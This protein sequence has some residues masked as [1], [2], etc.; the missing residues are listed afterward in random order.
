MCSVCL[1]ICFAKRK[2]LLFLK[3]STPVL[4]LLFSIIFI[5]IIIISFLIIAK[6][7]WAAAVDPS[8]SPAQRHSHSPESIPKPNQNAQKLDF[9]MHDNLV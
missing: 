6:V 8:R 2:Y 4:L 7:S 5:T 1:E 9:S 3:K